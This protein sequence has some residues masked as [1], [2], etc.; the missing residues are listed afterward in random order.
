MDL[1]EATKKYLDN[2]D[3]ECDKCPL[4]K[5]A[6]NVTASMGSTFC[7]IYVDLE[8]DLSSIKGAEK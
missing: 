4:N 6:K 5:D 8:A 7:N 3:H 1:L 2:C